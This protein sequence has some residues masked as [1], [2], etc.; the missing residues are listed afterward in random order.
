[1]N[2]AAGY[3][4]TLSRGAGD[5]RRRTLWRRNRCGDLEGQLEWTD[6]LKMNAHASATNEP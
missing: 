5:L 4:I 1:M 6:L 2:S 3:S